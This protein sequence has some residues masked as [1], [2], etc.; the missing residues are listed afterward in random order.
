MEKLNQTLELNL[1]LLDSKKVRIKI[2][3]NGTLRNIES[4]LL[5]LGFNQKGV[6]FTKE[7]RKLKDYDIKNL[8][9]GNTI[10]LSTGIKGGYFYRGPDAEQMNLMAKYYRFFKKICRKCNNI[11]HVKDK[12]C[13]NKKCGNGRTLRLRKARYAHEKNKF[14]DIL[15]THSFKNKN[16]N[17][18]LL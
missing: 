3:K 6:I 9:N 16:K 15:R 5:N 10:E 12:V 17:K 1:I 7:G 13:R 2:P 18:F 11:H 14:K 8:E 4:E